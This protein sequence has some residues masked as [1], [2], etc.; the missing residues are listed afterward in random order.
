MQRLG[1]K[2]KNFVLATIH[3]AENTE[4]PAKL[5]SIME[6]LNHIARDIQ[7]I[8]HMHPRT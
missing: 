2:I 5:G 3:R 1:F 8:L 4:N 6:A 7:V